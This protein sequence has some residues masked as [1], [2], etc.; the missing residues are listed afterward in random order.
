VRR[1]SR[2]RDAYVSFGSLSVP[3]SSFLKGPRD[4][5]ED[6]QDWALADLFAGFAVPG[7]EDRLSP[8]DCDRRLAQAYARQPD[9]VITAAI[10]AVRAASDRWAMLGAAQWLASLGPAAE[11]ALPALEAVA[12]ALDSY[13]QDRM[14][15]ASTFIRQSLLIAREREADTSSVAALTDQLDHPDVVVRAKA[16]EELALR[17]PSPEEIAAALPRLEHMLADESS[18][19]IG[20]AGLYECQGRL[21]HWRHERRSPRASAARALFAIGRVPP[22]DRMLAAMLGEVMHAQ[23]IC[24]AAAMP[25]RFTIAHWRLAAEA[26]GGLA[27]AEP[28]IRAA[29]QQCRSAPWPGHSGPQVCE[30]ELAEVIEVLSGRL[31]P[32]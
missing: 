13:A 27:R 24:G 16:A 28:R 4:R 25:P 22:D 32:S 20:V 30:A 23:A 26:A 31:G 17:S 6:P 5:L 2:R 9:K 1:Y 29:R 18:A 19:E 11:R 12:G 21:V 14:L 15:E 7:S 3:A 10:E 8:P